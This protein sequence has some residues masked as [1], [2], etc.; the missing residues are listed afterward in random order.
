MKK[1]FYK[2]LKNRNNE[3]IS[4]HK[5]ATQN[6]QK[7]TANKGSVN[8]KESKAKTPNHFIIIY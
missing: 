4:N 7:N 3:V 2:A 5:K 6:Y 1:I 8:K